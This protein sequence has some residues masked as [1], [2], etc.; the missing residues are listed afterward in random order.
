MI[1]NKLRD[2]NLLLK[3][4]AGGK[5]FFFSNTY[6]FGTPKQLDFEN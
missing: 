4:K 3:K 5:T 2:A 6:S 1:V